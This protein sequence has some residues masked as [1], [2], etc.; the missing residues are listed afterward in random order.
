MGI[1]SINLNDIKLSEEAKKELAEIEKEIRGDMTDEQWA[2]FETI[3]CVTPIDEFLRLEKE[4]GNDMGGRV[5]KR[6][7]GK[8]NTEQMMFKRIISKGTSKE[9]HTWWC[10]E[11]C[12]QISE[13]ATH[14]L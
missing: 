2:F 7:C 11:C 1:K 5:Q 3:R 6:K 8:C 10:P 14:L 13:G 9:C 4:A 12:D